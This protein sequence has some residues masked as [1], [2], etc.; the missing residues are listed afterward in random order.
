[1]SSL[2]PKR[3]SAIVALRVTGDADA[4]LRRLTDAKI[5]VSKHKQVIRVSPHY[6]NTEEEIARVGEVLGEATHGT[7]PA[8]I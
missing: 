5:T 6:Y 1:M 4:A 8:R 3:R 2:Q 7:Q